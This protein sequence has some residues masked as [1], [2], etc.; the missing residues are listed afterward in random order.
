MAKVSATSEVILPA[1]SLVAIARDVPLGE[2]A[3]AVGPMFD[4]LNK[5]ICAEGYAFYGPTVGLY[6]TQGDIMR[7]VVGVE[8]TPDVPGLMRIDIAPTKALTERHVLEMTDFMPAHDG[9]HT[10]AMEKGLTPGTWSREV[11]RGLN[12]KTQ[13][14]ECDIQLDIAG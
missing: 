11:Y 8:W 2:V 3:G 10:Y 14:F 6:N 9:I 5:A 1:A 4:E 7:C 12:P 13:L